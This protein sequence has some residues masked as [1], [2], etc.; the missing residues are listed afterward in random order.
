M[1]ETPQEDFLPDGFPSRD[2]EIELTQRQ[3]V[4]LE[5]AA[6]DVRTGGSAGA[7]WGLLLLACCGLR[8]ADLLNASFR[9]WDLLAGYA[10]LLCSLGALVRN[11]AAMALLAVIAA[12]DL[13]VQVL[14]AWDSI[15]QD[16]SLDLAAAAVR[17]GLLPLVLY[18]IAR[19]YRGSVD[20]HLL[21]GG[22]PLR[23][24]RFWKPLHLTAIF[25]LY[26][27]VAAVALM[28]WKGSFRSS[29]EEPGAKL[30]KEDKAVKALF[31]ELK[32]IDVK[33]FTTEG[34]PEL[35][36][37]ELPGPEKAAAK[38]LLANL[39]NLPPPVREAVKDAVAFAANTDQLGCFNEALRRHDGCGDD[40]CR[41]LSRIF[42]TACLPSTRPNKDFCTG[43]PWPTAIVETAAWR[44]RMC[45]QSKRPPGPCYAFLLT[46]QRFCYPEAGEKKG[47]TV[48]SK[49]AWGT[50]MRNLNADLLGA[51]VKPSGKG[52]GDQEKGDVRGTE[53]TDKSRD[54]RA[55]T[56]DD[57]VVLDKPVREAIEQAEVFA[58]QKDNASCLA[59]AV[60][61]YDACANEDCRFLATVFLSACL[62][63]SRPSNDFCIRVP[64]PISVEDTT[65]WLG[66]VCEDR[67]RAPAPCHVFFRSLQEYCHPEAVMELGA[68]LSRR[69]ERTAER[70]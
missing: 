10:L 51:G 3:L 49:H 36:V 17:L 24:W 37:N 5:Q 66:R 29:F 16:M 39:E 33:P 63:G 22:Q 54:P 41:M 58:T 30:A 11:Q 15:G 21:S 48:G 42:L 67:G 13:P 12:A 38:A 19:G 28:V 45:D 59:E 60:R 69:Q 35:P 6:R 4:L 65:I 18:L 50:L 56:R 2:L 7:L 27:A 26:V 14:I 47:T 43:M 1:D 62:H 61:R 53:G 25:T 23:N 44:S 9:Y 46:A 20:H 34:D 32:K 57:A 31:A 70:P 64:S 40:D 52:T 68:R 8:F 55:A